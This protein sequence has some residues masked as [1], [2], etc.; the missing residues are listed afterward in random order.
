MIPILNKIFNSRPIT[1]RQKSAYIDAAK[2]ERTERI[3]NLELIQQAQCQI[4]NIQNQIAM[5]PAEKNE[6]WLS[7]YS[8]KVH[9]EIK[10]RREVKALLTK[11]KHG[12][13]TSKPQAPKAA[14]KPTATQ[15]KSAAPVVN[16]LAALSDGELITAATHRSAPTAGKPAARAELLR[17]GITVS[18][19]GQCIIRSHNFKPTK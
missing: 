4:D 11:T 12:F 14:A 7:N 19:D 5:T 9:A 1:A 15:P 13:L 10:G 2:A 16:L 3:F 8:P 6:F 18:E 17:R